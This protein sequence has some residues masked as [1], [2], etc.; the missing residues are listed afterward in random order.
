MKV[1]VAVLGSLSLNHVLLV[2]V[3]VTE[4]TL[5]LGSPEFTSC[6]NAQVDALGSPSLNHVLLVSV[7]VTEAT[8]N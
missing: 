3:D 5:N 2:S 8:L 6:V 7:D 1:E 4:A